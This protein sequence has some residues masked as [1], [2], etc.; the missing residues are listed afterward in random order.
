LILVL[1]LPPMPAHGRMRVD[2]YKDGTCR[3]PRVRLDET[4]NRE[5]VEWVGQEVLRQGVCSYREWRIYETGRTPQASEI[6][7]EGAVH[8]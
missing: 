4:V 1:A 5:D 8:G 2:V 3:Y 6:K 7:A